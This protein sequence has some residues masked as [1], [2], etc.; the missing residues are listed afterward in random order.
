MN[1][2]L[3]RNEPKAQV[4]SNSIRSIGYSLEAAIADIIDNSITA[5]ASKIEV[6][7]PFSPNEVY[8]AICDNGHGM[9]KDELFDAMKYGSALKG[10]NRSEDDLGRFGMGLKSASLSQCRRL[11]VISKK[12]GKVSAYIGD[13]D[14]VSQYKDW[15]MKY[16]IE[17]ICV[18]TKW[19]SMKR[20][21]KNS[22]M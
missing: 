22:L 5:K 4:L 3:T 21:K 16:L 14:I 13:L 6:K 10:E 20:F 11:S 9:S 7:F 1:P 2:T 8:I 19:L 12:N 15:M 17:D 18:L